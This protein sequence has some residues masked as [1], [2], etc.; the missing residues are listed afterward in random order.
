MPNP[1]D[2]AIKDLKASSDRLF[3]AAQKRY[4]RYKKLADNAKTP[5]QKKVGERN[6][7]RVV[8]SLKAHQVRFS[9]TMAT[10]NKLKPK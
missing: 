6:M 9:K 10:L 8:E 4:A 7:K 1:I 5:A 3:A 2:T